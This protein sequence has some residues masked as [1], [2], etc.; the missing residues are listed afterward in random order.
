MEIADLK[1][2]LLVQTPQRQVLKISTI[3]DENRVSAQIVYPVPTRTSVE[4]F[5]ATDVSTWREPTKA[6]LNRY[7][8]A[9]GRAR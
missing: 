9:Y 4:Y 6:M 3:Y 2:N 8:E 5:N 7:D 1:P